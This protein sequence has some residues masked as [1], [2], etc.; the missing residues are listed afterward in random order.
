VGNCGLYGGRAK[1]VREATTAFGLKGRHLRY[2]LS[3]DLTL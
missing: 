1:K 3:G 2:T